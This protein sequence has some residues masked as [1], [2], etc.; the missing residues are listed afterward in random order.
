[1]NKVRKP[2]VI[3]LVVGLMLSVG[4]L[5]FAFLSIQESFQN[6]SLE[7]RVF[8]H[9]FVMFAGVLN[10]II[11][12]RTKRRYLQNAQEDVGTIPQEG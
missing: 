6:G 8:L 4:E 12:F 5:P 7:G 10:I 3:Q 9:L 2:L 1:M 11:Y